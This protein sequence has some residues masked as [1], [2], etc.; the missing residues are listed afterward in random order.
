VVEGVVAA[1]L[2]LVSIVDHRP[3]LGQLAPGA[4]AVTDHGLLS[5]LADDD[6]TQYLLTSGRTMTGDQNMGGNAITNVGNVDGVDVS[7]HAGR[8][9]NAGADEI[10]VGGLSGALADDQPAQ[11]HTLG[12]AKHTADTIANVDA[13]V[14]DATLVAEIENTT[15]TTT[16]TPFNIATIA[17]PDDTVVLIEVRIVARRTDSA[18]RATYIRHAVVFREAAGVATL[19]GAVDTPFTRESTGDSTW[20][21][22]ILVDGG[23]NALIEVTG[24]GAKTINWKS[25]HRTRQVS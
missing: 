16:G 24:Q 7:A 18:G 5:G 6:H 2:A 22:T 14:S 20:D 23:N 21:A 8:H 4:T 17:I 10:N 15:T 25:L 9:E 13:K 12:G 11:A 19:E 1:S 3:F